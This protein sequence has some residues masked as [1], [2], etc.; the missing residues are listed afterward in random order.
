MPQGLP[1]SEIRI[2]LGRGGRTLQIAREGLSL[3]HAMEEESK[4]PLLSASCAHH[5][6]QARQCYI[7][8]TDTVQY[9]WVPHFSSHGERLRIRLRGRLRSTSQYE[10][11]KESTRPFPVDVAYRV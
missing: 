1:V 6:S 10:I 3:V 5:D 2:R 4:L 11:L 7:S 9:I 8:Q